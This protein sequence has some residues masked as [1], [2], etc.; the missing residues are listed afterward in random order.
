MASKKKSRSNN[1]RKKRD[2]LSRI[3]GEERKQY[4]EDGGT[5]A[6]W[7]GVSAIHRDKK[8]KRSNRSTKERKAIQESEEG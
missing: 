6:G 8:E 2:M 3:R 5:L 1:R 4:F 7:R